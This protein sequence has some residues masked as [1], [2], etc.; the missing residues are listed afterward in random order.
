MIGLHIQSA[1]A[2]LEDHYFLEMDASYLY[3]RTKPNAAPTKLKRYGDLV[4]YTSVQRLVA[5][6]PLSPK[7]R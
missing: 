7:G 3:V 5:T 1:K 4:S 2:K 6:R